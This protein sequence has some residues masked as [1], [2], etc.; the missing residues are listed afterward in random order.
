MRFTILVFPGSNCD[1]DAYNAVKHVLG[2]EATFVWH[3]ETDLKDPD[4]VILPGGFS[5]GDYLRCGAM[6]S[7]SPAMEQVKAFADQGGLVIGICNGFQ[8][9]VNLGLLPGLNGDYTRRSVALT[10]ND[11]GNFRDDWVALRVHPDS[12]C[13]YTRGIERLEL[14]VR[15]GE[16]KFYTR[17]AV[18][19]RLTAAGQIVLQYA[20]PDGRPAG[21]EF[22]YNPNGSLADIAGICDP[23]G[24]VFGLMPHPEAY[25]H[26]TNH[27]DWTR[28]RH[29][30][31]SN[32]DN[33]PKAVPGTRIFENA[34]K[35]LQNGG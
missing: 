20:R 13:V 4:C 8:T 31:R 5:Y 17:A 22:P 12:P 14:P 15:H 26:P 34:V 27:P 21:G 32:P 19:D 6:A 10:Y 23:T 28:W 3:G 25:L 30:R 18:I 2:H 33:V 11:C 24:R 35:F 16:G 9:L 1:Y 7:F 29:M